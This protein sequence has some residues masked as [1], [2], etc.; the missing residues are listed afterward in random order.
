MQ[1]LVIILAMAGIVWM[2]KLTKEND[3]VDKFDDRDIYD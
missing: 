1:A 3:D 2:V